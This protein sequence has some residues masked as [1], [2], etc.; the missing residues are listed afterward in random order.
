MNRLFGVAQQSYFRPSRLLLQ[1]RRH[2]YNHNSNSEVFIQRQQQEQQH[3]Q[4]FQHIYNNKIQQV[5]PHQ[6]RT[7]TAAASTSTV[8]RK[9]KRHAAKHDHLDSFLSSKKTYGHSLISQ[10]RELQGQVV[11]F[12]SSLV[13]A[14]AGGSLKRKFLLQLKSGNNGRNN[15]SDGNNNSNVSVHAIGVLVKVPASEFVKKQTATA[16]SSSSSSSP[17]SRAAMRRAGGANSNV[18]TAQQ[19]LQKLQ[20]NQNQNQNNN[21]NS[22]NASE[23]AASTTPM[24]T[25]ANE[26]KD[27]STKSADEHQQQ[28]Q[29]QQT[30]VNMLLFY[31]NRELHSCWEREV[32]IIDKWPSTVL[33]NIDE[34]E[35]LKEQ[36]ISQVNNKLALALSTTATSTEVSVCS[37]LFIV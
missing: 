28:Q 9:K 29:Q 27:S 31:K 35:Q 24:S 5:Q 33:L 1:Q 10:Y 17:T 4:H 20:E 2:Y 18:L 30:Y 3:L 14:Q 16:A 22:N 19:L 8:D 25:I 34:L 13:I 32:Q 23:A 36:V 12:E 15:A 6:T 26:T 7:F 11:V 37:V 21:S